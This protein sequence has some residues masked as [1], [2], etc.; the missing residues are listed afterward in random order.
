LHQACLLNSSSESES[1]QLQL[2]SAARDAIAAAT[3]GTPGQDSHPC[4]SHCW[5]H[6]QL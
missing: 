6:Y 4:C 2:T 3:P 5:R 1:E